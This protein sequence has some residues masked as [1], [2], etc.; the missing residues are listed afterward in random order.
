[1]AWPT[2]VWGQI[3]EG[4]RCLVALTGLRQ[5]NLHPIDTVDAVDE[6]N[7]DED[8]GDLQAVLE[9]RDDGIL[10]DKTVAQDFISHLLPLAGQ[11]GLGERAREG[12]VDS[13]E[14]LPLD[15]EGKRN[16]EEHKQ[17]HLCHEQEEDLA[18]ELQ[19]VVGQTSNGASC[20]C[21]EAFPTYQAVVQSHIRCLSTTQ[22]SGVLLLYFVE[23]KSRIDGIDSLWPE[24]QK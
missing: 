10:G 22:S 3:E 15:C 2:R 23:R 13:R 12:F 14:H 16:D 7:Q 24:F 5:F 20:S 6:E 18:V 19:L 9:L 4:V 11:I 8:E 1:M 17:T 21:N